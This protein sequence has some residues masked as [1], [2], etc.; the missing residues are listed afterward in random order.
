MADLLCMYEGC[1]HTS[2]QIGA[3]LE[4]ICGIL[5]HPPAECPGWSCMGGVRCLNRYSY[6]TVVHS[7]SKVC[8]VLF[9]FFTLKP[10]FLPVDIQHNQCPCRFVN[11]RKDKSSVVTKLRHRDNTLPRTW[12]EVST[13]GNPMPWHYGIILLY[14]IR[15]ARHKGEEY[16]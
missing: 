10:F 9:V 7:V 13:V 11:P 5:V 16:Y 14:W 3:V 4:K 12:Y 8:T 1:S 2:S 6:R 15:Q